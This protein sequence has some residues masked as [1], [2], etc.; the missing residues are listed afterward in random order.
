MM[1][2]F[3][4]TPDNSDGPFIDFKRTGKLSLSLQFRKNTLDV[5]YMICYYEYDAVIEIYKNNTITTKV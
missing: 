5:I 3:D 4:L 1:I 2:C